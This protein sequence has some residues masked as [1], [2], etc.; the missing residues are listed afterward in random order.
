M[1]LD[2]KVALVTGAARR[3]GRAIALGLAGRGAKLIVHYGRS[4]EDAEAVAAEI[5]GLGNSAATLRAN[6]NDLQEVQNLVQEA[7]RAFGPIDILI[8]SASVFHRTP[9]GS[10]T[11]EQWNELLDTNLRAPFFLAQAFG[12]VMKARGGGKII[13]LGDATMPYAVADF[14]PYAASK[15]GLEA[16]T[17]GLAR[18]LAPEVQVN[19][20]LPGPVLPA[21]GGEADQWDKAIGQTVLKRPGAPEDIVEAVLFLLEKG[22][23]LTGVFLPVD[24]GRSL[25][26]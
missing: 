18:A 20:I 21:Q 22:D 11:P 25:G 2:G 16:I 26:R 8:N 10:V 12:T 24:G 5:E 1:E 7:P 15:A 14:T 19:A 13:N 4:R 3:L 17:R 6:L 23:F 9:L